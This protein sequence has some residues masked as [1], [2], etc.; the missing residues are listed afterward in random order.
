MLGYQNLVVMQLSLHSALSLT[1]SCSHK[2][3]CL[4]P[5]S[6]SVCLIMFS[7]SHFLW[8]CSR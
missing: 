2:I 5:M 6:F 8:T 4:F 7:H 3:P 1:P